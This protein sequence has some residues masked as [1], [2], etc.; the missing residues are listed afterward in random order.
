MNSLVAL[1]LKNSMSQCPQKHVRLVKIGQ[2]EFRWQTEYAE[3][4]D[5]K[6]CS[7][8]KFWRKQ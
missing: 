2:K 8:T 5:E 4:I 1:E 3:I 7:L 6:G